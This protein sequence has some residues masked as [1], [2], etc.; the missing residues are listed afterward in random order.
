MNKID[1]LNFD[2]VP[3]LWDKRED[4][5]KENT[6]DLKDISAID[7]S[8][9]ALLVKWAKAQKDQKLHLINVPVSAMNLINTYRLGQLFVLD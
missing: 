6:V 4:L 3:S 1:K 5:F 2:S 7:V 8:G 9:M